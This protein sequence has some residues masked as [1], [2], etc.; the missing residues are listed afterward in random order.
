M[1]KTSIKTPARK[2]PLRTVGVGLRRGP[3]AKRCSQGQ[4]PTSSAVS[5]TAGITVEKQ[6]ELRIRY[7]KSPKCLSPRYC[8]L[9]VRLLTTSKSHHAGADKTKRQANSR[10]E[11]VSRE[12]PVDL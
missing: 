4:L 1:A 11:R 10:G 5:K 3:A 6:S 12:L 2:R 9:P 7:S 8:Q